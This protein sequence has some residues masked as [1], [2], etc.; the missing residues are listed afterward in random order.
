MVNGI[1]TALPAEL[2]PP[3]KSIEATIG[4]TT[5]WAASCIAAEI[6]EWRVD[7]RQPETMRNATDAIATLYELRAAT[8]ATGEIDDFEAVAQAE[9]FRALREHCD[10]SDELITA[11]INGV[12]EILGD[13]VRSQIS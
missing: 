12:I 7:K 9:G 8:L 1:K 2:E 11:L 3:S 4:Q 13:V 10:N 5:A 6:E